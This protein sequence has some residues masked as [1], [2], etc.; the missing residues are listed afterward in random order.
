MISRRLTAVDAFAI[1][2]GIIMIALGLKDGSVFPSVVCMGI[3]CFIPVILKFSGIIELPAPIVV[4]IVIAPWLH[5]LGL[6]MGYY[7]TMDNFDTVTHTLSSMVVAVI[8]F[9]ALSAVH[10]YGGGRVNFTGRGLAI[11]TALLSM[12]FSVYWEVL[13]FTSDTFTSSVTQYSPYDTIT[14]LVCDTLG[15]FLGSMWV[16]FYMRGR[17]TKDVVESFHLDDRI[18]PLIVGRMK[19]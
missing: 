11:L 18:L 12:S 3:I 6:A 14:D 16:A 7:V 15:T 17:T 8:I 9:Y 19:K 2:F 5:G 10:C 1:V 4:M 13:E